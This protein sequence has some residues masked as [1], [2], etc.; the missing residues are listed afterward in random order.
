MIRNEKEC[1]E[2]QRR[3]GDA[4][5]FATITSMS[6]QES[7]FPDP[8]FIKTAVIGRRKDF[9]AL[10]EGFAKLRAVSY[11]GSAGWRRTTR[12]TCGIRPFSWATSRTSS[13]RTGRRSAANS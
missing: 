11:R 1:M 4:D 2:P 8:D 12:L 5:A 6:R 10:F 9:D 7:L 13:S 3:Q